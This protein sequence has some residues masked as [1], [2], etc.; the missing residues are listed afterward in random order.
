MYF[1]LRNRETGCVM[2][3]T[4]GLDDIKLMRVQAVEETGGV[5]QVWLYRD[6]QV[7]CKV[8][9]HTS[10]THS[11]CLKTVCSWT[12]SGCYKSK[13]ENLHLL[14]THKQTIVFI[15]WPSPEALNSKSSL[16][17]GIFLPHHP[18]VQKSALC[19]KTQS[20]QNRTTVICLQ[21]LYFSVWLLFYVTMPLKT[22]AWLSNIQNRNQH[23]HY[24]FPALY[25]IMSHCHN[26]CFG[27]IRMGTVT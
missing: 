1:R 21:W 3:L 18:Q 6:G 7:T 22:R 20:F 5:E 15:E 10:T 16:C 25:I 19:T 2:S 4:G 9:K 24:D 26:Q 8:L 27:L 11:C 13:E 14:S 23:F 17:I 12:V